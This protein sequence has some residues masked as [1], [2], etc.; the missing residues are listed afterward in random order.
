MKKEAVAIFVINALSLLI[1]NQ[2]VL[3]Q[4]AGHGDEESIH[5]YRLSPGS[6]EAGLS[7]DELSDNPFL[8]WE[9]EEEVEKDRR[10]PLDYLRLS[11]A[12]HSKGVSYAV[13]DGRIVKEGSLVDNKEVVKIGAEEVTLK[14]FLG[15]EY[16]VKM[17]K[18]IAVPVPA[19]SESK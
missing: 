3:S 2:A 13:I 5:Q 6:L 15:T 17:S 8:T 19:V 16:V 9:E 14:D 18:I 7:K 4:S 12:L 10:V 1:V 11:A